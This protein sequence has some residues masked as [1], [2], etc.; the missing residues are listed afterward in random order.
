MSVFSSRD[1]LHFRVISR[2]FLSCL[3]QCRVICNILVNVFNSKNQQGLTEIQSTA[4]SS[5]LKLI[6][7][8]ISLHIKKDRYY[9][10]ESKSICIANN[11][12]VKQSISIVKLLN[13]V[14]VS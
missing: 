8:H 14:Y 13:D 11:T 2:Y 12:V 6:R 5:S 9:C 7:V 3:N 1:S 4:I 10:K